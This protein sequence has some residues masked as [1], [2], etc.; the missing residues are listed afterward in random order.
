MKSNS[1]A[2]K[3]EIIEEPKLDTEIHR[4]KKFSVTFTFKSKS[5][6]FNPIIVEM[7]FDESTKKILPNNK[8]FDKMTNHLKEWKHVV[9]WMWNKYL[10]DKIKGYNY[11]EKTIDGAGDYCILFLFLEMVSQGWKVSNTFWYKDNNFERR[12]YEEENIKAYAQRFGHHGCKNGNDN[13]FSYLDN[14]FKYQMKSLDEII[15]PNDLPSEIISQLYKL[16]SFCQCRIVTPN[17]KNINP[18]NQIQTANINLPNKK[19]INDAGNTLNQT[20]ANRENHEIIKTPKKI[21]KRGTETNPEVN[22]NSGAIF[23]NKTNINQNKTGLTQKLINDTNNILKPIDASFENRTTNQ[24]QQVINERMIKKGPEIDLKSNS[25]AISTNQTNI[26]QNKNI[27]IQGKDNKLKEIREPEILEQLRNSKILVQKVFD[28][29]QNTLKE[30]Q[31]KANVKQSN[32]AHEEK[33]KQ[34]KAI[35]KRKSVDLTYKCNLVFLYIVLVLCLMIFIGV[36]L[37]V[38]LSGILLTL[39]IGIPIIVVTILA[40]IGF[41][42]SLTELNKLKQQ[43]SDI[44]LSSDNKSANYQK[45]FV[46]SRNTVQKQGKKSPFLKDINLKDRLDDKNNQEHDI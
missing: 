10:N 30:Q 16:Q 14:L 31:Q 3:K 29:V 8:Y 1:N 40:A 32:I 33:I 42:F 17:T 45:L 24:P 36:P 35:V 38:F 6:N 2:E 41:V 13:N 34:S 21:K 44:L 22:L 4:I 15:I 18:D 7:D 46:L 12:W 39:E 5:G 23:T 26:N 20:D 28:S 43:N 9:L 19:L 27:L 11:N 25:N 37:N